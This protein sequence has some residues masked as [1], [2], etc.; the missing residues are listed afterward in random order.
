MSDMN[1]I[2]LFAGFACVIVWIGTAKKKREQE[3]L[4]D[5][6]LRHKLHLEYEKK[7][8][9]IERYATSS[10]APKK[11]SKTS[12]QLIDNALASKNAQDNVVL[13]ALPTAL[14]NV[15]STHGKY[16]N[17]V[18]HSDTRYEID[19]DEQTCSCPRFDGMHQFPKNHMGRICEH[20]F[21]E[22]DR[23]KAFNRLQ[24]N[25]LTALVLGLREETRA[26]YTLKHEELPLA[27][28]IVG[29]NDD[30]LNIYVREKLTGQ[31]IHDA[32]G[33]FQRYGWS[34]SEKRWSFG[35]GP[36][37][38]SYLRNF[39]STLS[40]ADDLKSLSRE[41]NPSK[42]EALE[43]KKLSELSDPRYGADE[44]A[45]QFGPPK[46]AYD[47][48]DSLLTDYT[49][50][51]VS[52]NFRYMDSK[53]Q[54][55]RRTVD[56]K[57][58]QYYGNE[59]EFIYGECRMRRAG[60]TFKTSRMWDAVDVNTGEVVENVT[61]YLQSAYAESALGRLRGWMENNERIARGWLYL[62]KAN[63]RPSRAEYDVLKQAFS[64]ILD[65]QTITTKDIQEFFHD[66][67]V[68]TPIGFQRIVSGVK[69]H[70]PDQAQ[71]FA[72][73]CHALVTCRK[74]PNFADEA[75]LKFV[76]E[77]IPLH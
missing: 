27:Y 9:D 5:E 24:H 76:V 63:K 53:G 34:C 49:A 1:L 48:P 62:L 20:I 19:L 16:F 26:A 13:I 75:A 32:S 8:A 33:D 46:D 23:Q 70:H 65:G 73:V 44:N 36:S 37:G 41:F 66:A 17:E 77:K 11:P 67:T 57:E 42:Q 39:L 22:M 31:S 43:K 15:H 52:L 4:D 35:I 18:P 71:T 56:V 64:E 50:L 45:D 12:K 7:R 74:N 51:S 54:K 59:G 69:K 47:I 28:V 30:W 61:E 38:A 58:I 72:K 25:V 14:E 21:V 68:T 55:S 6:Q 2:L 3:E 60:R 10:P 40:S 29:K